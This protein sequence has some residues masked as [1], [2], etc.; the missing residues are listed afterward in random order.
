[1]RKPLLVCLAII[2][3]GGPSGFAQKDPRPSIQP[4]KFE[5]S[6]SKTVY[7]VGEAVELKLTLTNTASRAVTGGFGMR[8]N[9]DLQV[10][11]AR[12]GQPKQGFF[13]RLVK[14]RATDYTSSIPMTLKPGASTS[15]TV[16]LLH[17]YKPYTP[18][19]SEPGTYEVGARFYFKHD[20]YS[21]PVETNTL[22]I[23]V[24][25]SGEEQN[26]AAWLQWQDSALLDFVQSSLDGVTHHL[27]VD[28]QIAGGQKAEVFIS[29][30]GGSPYATAAKKGMLEYLNGRST[31]LTESQ[32]ILLDQ[33]RREFPES[34]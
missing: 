32:E 4:P 16:W 20:G 24:V 10:W 11:T 7:S 2:L 19:F 23:T 33:L 28:A 21:Y 15:L 22:T 30:F 26:K 13:S 18:V 12:Q 17:S 31:S 9:N 34:K 5:G 27:N 25:E 29:L 3:L 14:S 1:M 6:T 8:V